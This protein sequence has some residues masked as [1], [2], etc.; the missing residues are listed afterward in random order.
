MCTGIRLIAEDKS[1]IFG[2]TLEFGKDLESNIIM[3]PRNYEFQGTG[4]ARKPDGLKWKSKYAAVGANAMGITQIIDGVNEAG[5]AGGL[6]YFPGYAQYQD[7]SGAQTSNSIASWELMTWILTNF[8]DVNEVKNK[9]PEIF[10]SKVVFGPWNMVLP[11]H[12]VIH[13]SSG[14]SLV[15]EYL[16]GNLVMTNNPIGVFTNAPTFDW[17]LTNLNNYV[18]LSPVNI[19]SPKIKNLDLAPLGQ[20]SGWIGLP[21]DLTSPSRFIR[22]VAFSQSVIGLKTENE[23]RDCAF[24]IL[25]LFDIPLGIVRQKESSSNIT[26]YEYTEWTSVSDLKN[27]RYYFCTYGNRNLRMIDLMKLNLDSKE[28]V[29]FEMQSKEKIFEQE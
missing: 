12:A 28:P 2:R 29:I 4:P 5:L 16:N 7:V 18:G 1:V 15:I 17:H 19:E 23:A 10:V 11:V 3:I 8:A 14:N 25:N 9:L 20:G 26:Q 24:H 27:K 22:A 6:F 21:G 13:D